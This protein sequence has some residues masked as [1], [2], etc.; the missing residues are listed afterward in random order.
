MY[1]GLTSRF[2]IYVV[3]GVVVLDNVSVNKV[4]QIVILTLVFANVGLSM[5][6]WSTLLSYHIVVKAKFVPS[7]AYVGS[8]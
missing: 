3:G 7:L 8:L 6:G 4:S 1:R 2:E 5:A